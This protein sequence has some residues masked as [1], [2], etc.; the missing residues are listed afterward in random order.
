[1]DAKISNIDIVREGAK[2]MINYAEVNAQF[3]NDNNGF[4]TL[5]NAM[6]RYASNEGILSA[7]MLLFRNMCVTGTHHPKYFP[8]LSY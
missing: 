7:F 5:S 4:E 2:S 8:I 6:S 1:M 3:I